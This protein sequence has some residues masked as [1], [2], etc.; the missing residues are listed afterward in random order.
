MNEN[1]YC[2]DALN[3]LRGG[4]LLKGVEEVLPLLEPS[5]VRIVCEAAQPFNR[6]SIFEFQKEEEKVIFSLPEYC[7]LINKEFGPH[8][9]IIY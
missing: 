7:V 2:P 4:N 6:H 5:M 9:K 8:Q 3:N 1:R